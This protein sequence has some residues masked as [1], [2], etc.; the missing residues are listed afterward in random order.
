MKPVILALSLS[1][2][3]FR[4]LIFALLWCLT[5][6][7]IPNQNPMGTIHRQQGSY[8]E[9]TS[10]YTCTEQKMI[11]AVLN[12]VLQ[13]KYYDRDFFQ[14]WQILHTN[15]HILYITPIT[16]HSIKLTG[17]YDDNSSIH[18]AGYFHNEG[19]LFMMRTMHFLALHA[20][21]CGKSGEFVGINMPTSSIIFFRS[22]LNDVWKS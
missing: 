16:C 11:W 15:A 9:R 20:F 21:F 12:L 22:Q 1:D 6:C 2:H 14:I 8:A 3:S 18:I 5:N 10:V 17:W 13:K 4:Q 19:S 7:F